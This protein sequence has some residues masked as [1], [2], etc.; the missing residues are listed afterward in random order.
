MKI[1]ITGANGYIGANVVRSLADEHTLT[2]MVRRSNNNIP[3]SLNCIFHDIRL[4]IT[5]NETFD[6]IIHIAGNPS[7][8][9]CIEDSS[10]ALHDNII[11]TFNV[12]EF[13]RL[14]SCKK[15]IF[16]SSCEVYGESL[17]A[18]EDDPLKSFN[19]YGASKI[20]CEHMCSAYYHSYGFETCVVIRLIHSWGPFCQKERFP[21]IVEHRFKTEKC[22][23]FIIDTKDKKRWIHTSEVTR[24]LKYLFDFKGYEVF[25]FTGDDNITL[26]EFISKHGD[27][28]TYEYRLDGLIN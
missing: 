8:K 10:S 14:S 27:N 12:L 1:L 15:I 21:S 24:K 17:D 9:S 7:S 19:M 23:H 18:H 11:G 5:L 22:P 2:C 26:L 6:M 25:N 28:F 16:F 3:S 4:P 13:A 20:A